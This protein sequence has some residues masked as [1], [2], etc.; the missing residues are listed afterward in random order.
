M[1]N[2]QIA[3]RQYQNDQ[4]HEALVTQTKHKVC[5]V[6]GKPPVIVWNRDAWVATCSEHRPTPCLWKKDDS[7]KER[8]GEMVQHAM[9]Q[10]PD[11]MPMSVSEIKQFISPNATEAEAYVFLRF[12]QSQ[13][14]NPFINDAYLIKYD[15]SAKASIVIGIQA[16]LKRAASNPAYSGYQ[17]GVV[18]MRDGKPVELDGSLVFNDSDVLVGGWAEIRRHDWTKPT[19]VTVS[20]KEYNKRQAQ[21]SERPATMIE[22][23]ALAQGLRRVFPQEVGALFEQ[24]GLET[25]VGDAEDRKVLPLQEATTPAS[26]PSLAEAPAPPGVP[27]ETQ[28]SLP[29]QP[30]IVPT[31]GAELLTRGV[32]ELG[33]KG[34]AEIFAVLKVASILEIKDIPA[35]WAQLKAGAAIPGVRAWQEE[36]LRVTPR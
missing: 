30:Y 26:T 9:V 28:R 4:V 3:E 34:R 35:A 23:V 14:L 15:R 7:Q 18:V 22:K 24:Q 21:W 13:G 16:L 32:N 1:T 25:E 11:K 8:Y 20:L 10:R 5:R 27:A 33:Y 12:C 6:S 17:C 19:K 36:S 2:Q 31:S 29:E